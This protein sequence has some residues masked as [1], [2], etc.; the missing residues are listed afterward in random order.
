MP[1]LNVHCAI[2]KERTN[3]DFRELHQWIDEPYKTLGKN[4]R[5]KRHAYNESEEN[6]I[7]NFWEDK[8]GE[9]WGDKAVIE[10]LFHITIDNLETAYKVSKKRYGKRAFN[11]FRF[12]LVPDS[13]FIFLDSEA[14]EKEDI[15]EEFEDK[16]DYEEEE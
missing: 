11:F 3:F 5:M 10:W 8:M 4:H 1:S 7:R 2:S 14:L 15:L 6:Q 13:R 9:G 12:G 16:Y